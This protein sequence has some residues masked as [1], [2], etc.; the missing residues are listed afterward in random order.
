M[1]GAR[2]VALCLLATLAVLAVAQEDD[3]ETV[4]A[5]SGEAGLAA[6]LTGT[7]NFWHG[8]IA[9]LSVI[10]VSELGDKTFFI[11]AIMAMRHSRF[12]VL[13]GALGALA[14]MTVLS[15]VMGYATTII[16][17]IYTFYAST[18]LFVF[19]GLKLLREGS[20]M[21]PDEES[22]ELEEVTLEL[23]KK[24]EE[25]A[26]SR[27]GTGDIEAGE[28][29][30]TEQQARWLGDIRNGILLQAFTMTFLAE[31]GD[32]SQI[33]TIVL[34]ARENVW[35][36]TIGGT[37]GHAICTG[38]AVVGGRLLAQRISVRTVTLSGGVVFLLFAASSLYF[39]PDQEGM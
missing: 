26:K 25:M 27:Q 6:S 16:P 36:V 18:L 28:G 9:S 24:E 14:L 38:I 13:A 39:G 3:T 22:D 17:R 7:G 2:R 1:A 10:I 11:A 21:S 5:H 4:Q 20:R 34:A 32:R 35:G 19:F 33:T 8:F 29:G 23:K 12:I 15:S 37:L 31:W 30:L